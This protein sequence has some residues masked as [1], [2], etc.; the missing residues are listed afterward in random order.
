MSSLAEVLLPAMWILRI[1]RI[2]L[3]ERQKI[4][5]AQNRFHLL[6]QDNVENFQNGLAY[7]GLQFNKD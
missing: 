3:K 7:V 4:R 1:C 2:A 6:E 5:R